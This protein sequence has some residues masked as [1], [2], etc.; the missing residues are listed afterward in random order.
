MFKIEAGQTKNFQINYT[1]FLPVTNL[2]TKMAKATTRRRC[3]KLPA[4]LVISPNNQSTS[5]IM[6]IVS[7]ISAFSKKT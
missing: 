7:N 1:A 4:V 2:I 3:I 5:K 6:I